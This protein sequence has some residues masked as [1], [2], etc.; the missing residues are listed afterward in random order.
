[1]TLDS[2]LNVPGLGVGRLRGRLRAASE[3]DEINITDDAERDALQAAL[4]AA[5]QEPRYFT[6]ALPALLEAARTPI[7]GPECL[8]SSSSQST[9]PCSA[10]DTAP[11]RTGLLGA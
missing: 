8:T 9:A 1:S 11:G 4:E 5:S 6:G 2:F 3:G 10:P 7:S